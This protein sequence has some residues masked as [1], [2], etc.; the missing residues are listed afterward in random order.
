MYCL[1]TYEEDV[2]LMRYSYAV[3]V[4][5]ARYIVCLSSLSIVVCHRC[6]VAK[7]CEIGPRLLL[8]TNK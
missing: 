2:F 1:Y 8:I 6:N 7:R 3:D 5:M 4:Y